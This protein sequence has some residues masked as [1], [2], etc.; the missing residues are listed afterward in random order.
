MKFC[1]LEGKTIVITGA[2]SGIGR[3]CA[4][5][6]SMLGAEIVLIGR[7]VTKLKGVLNDLDGKNH[8]YYPCDITDFSKSEELVNKIVDQKGKISGFIHSAGSETTIPLTFTKPEVFHKLFDLNVISGFE[9]VRHLTLKRNICERGASIV[10][11]SSIMSTVGQ[12]AKTAY[13]ASKGAIVAG[14]RSL[15]LEL[16]PK[17]IRVNAVSPSIVLT[18][19]VEQMFMKVSDESKKQIINMHPLG[20]GTPTDVANACAFLL[21][22]EAKW[23][24]GSNLIVDGGYSV[25]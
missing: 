22:D 18:P 16:A 10:F 1:A 20:L 6:C 2:S 25:S 3:E 24:T 7:D 17:K 14:I 5:T 12:P 15:S 11:I 9:L 4:I 19:L 8:I 23:I 13:S 21:S